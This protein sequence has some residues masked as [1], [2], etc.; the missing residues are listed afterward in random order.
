MFFS[1]VFKKVYYF[2]LISTPQSTPLRKKDVSLHH[3]MK[4]KE[5]TK[6]WQG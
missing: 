5:T 2:M 4:L 1:L 6:Q 3:Q